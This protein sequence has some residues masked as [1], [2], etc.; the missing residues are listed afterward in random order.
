MT[1]DDLTSLKN[2]EQILD[3][4]AEDPSIKLIADSI[5]DKEKDRPGSRS[6][7]KIYDVSW[8]GFGCEIAF[9]YA[10]PRAQIVNLGVIKHSDTTYQNL[11]RDVL[12]DGEYI[13][14][15]GLDRTNYRTR[16]WISEEQQKSIQRCAKFCSKLVF[17]SYIPKG[18]RS[19]LFS[20]TGVITNLKEFAKNFHGYAKKTENSHSYELDVFVAQKRKIYID[21]L[22]NSVYNQAVLA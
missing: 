12:L 17:M 16:V 6:R 3:I 20:A 1:D 2:Y 7:E 9:R 21:F 18:N 15:K 4:Q 8:P 11:Q 13:A 19:Y 14:I 10:I 5:Y 22:D